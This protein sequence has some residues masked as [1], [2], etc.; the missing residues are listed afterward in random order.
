MRILIAVISA[1]ALTLLP[2]MPAQAGSADASPII[3]TWKGT[4]TGYEGGVYVSKEIKW[5]IT[6]S[7]GTSF[8]GTKSWRP[9][10][11]T[12]SAAELVVGVMLPSGEVRWAD[13]DGT[14]LGVLENS[15]RIRGTYLETGTDQAAFD[16]I[17]RKK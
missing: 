15:R 11:G 4:S 8:S 10:G 13:E 2:S 17:V 16:Q 1:I 9:A 12:W 5:V 14:F 6:R 7:K 3:G